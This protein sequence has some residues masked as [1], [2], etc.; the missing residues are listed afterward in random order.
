MIFKNKSLKV[1]ALRSPSKV[2]VLKKK[3]K[4]N[5]RTPSSVPSRKFQGGPSSVPKQRQYV[6]K[7][8]KGVPQ[9]CLNKDNM[10]QGGPS[11]VPKQ[12][13]YVGKHFKGVPQRCPN[14]K[15]MCVKK[16]FKSCF[17]PYFKVQSSVSRF[18]PLDGD[19]RDI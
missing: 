19:F 2:H 14:K 5:Q 11:S 3:S 6:G 4:K 7:H 10:F 17:I 12:R 9:R 8:F 15:K 16:R 1:Q 13:Q 18:H